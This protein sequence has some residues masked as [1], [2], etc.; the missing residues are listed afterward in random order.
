MVSLLVFYNEAFSETE[1]TRDKIRAI[2]KAFF[3]I[4]FLL[5]ATNVDGNLYDQKKIAF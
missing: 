1:L 4:K 2:F 5:V 3:L